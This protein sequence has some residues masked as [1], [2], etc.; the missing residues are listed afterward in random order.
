MSA[1]PVTIRPFAPADFEAAVDVLP[2]EWDA[3]GCDPDET[4]ELRRMDLAHTLTESPLRLLAERDGHIVGMLLGN[5]GPGDLPSDAERWHAEEKRASDAVADGSAAARARLAYIKR[6]E[7]VA[8]DL[9]MAAAGD[10]RPDGGEVVLFAVSPEARG[11]GAGGALL[12]EYERHVAARGSSGFWLSTDDDCTWQ[13][14][15]RH[16][17]ERIACVE[18]P[19]RD[20]VDGRPV[21]GC[22]ATADRPGVLHTYIYRKRV[23][24][25]PGAA[26]LAYL[27]FDR[28]RDF[29]QVAALVP[30]EWVSDEAGKEAH[31]LGCQLMVARMLARCTFALV[32]R[33]RDAAGA[34]EPGAPA[35]DAAGVVERDVPAA[36][37]QGTAGT[38]GRAAQAVDALAV[39]D[40]ASTPVPLLGVALGR[41]GRPA[42]EDARPYEE[43]AEWLEGR[44]RALPGGAQIMAQ[45]DAELACDEALLA[46][47][48]SRLPD[49]AEYVLFV[50]APAARG[51]GVGAAMITRFEDYLRARG[52][53]SYYLLTDTGCTYDWYDRHGFKRVAQA[54]LDY[55]S[56]EATR[57]SVRAEDDLRGEPAA[58][59]AF[60]VYRYDLVG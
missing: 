4:R 28:E 10:A 27:P 55:A 21:G 40:A 18:K 25:R 31:E 26:G 43:L 19:L 11:T 59:G 6:G 58:P 56:P 14:Y 38:A 54:Q 17:F 34:G 44:L 13:W 5:F 24:A 30:P 48:T 29:A 3:S 50:T 22:V 52:A 49:D 41:L 23:E 20:E 47:A 36:G 57:A 2:P 9:A 33:E 39:P 15:E 35:A 8:Y 42:P 45:Q 37:E 32:V 12:A 46:A 60:F 16:G 53:G 7:A 51:K 1:A